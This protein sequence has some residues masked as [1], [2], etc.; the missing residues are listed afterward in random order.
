MTSNAQWEGTVNMDCALGDK[1][2]EIGLSTTLLVPKLQ[3]NLIS[4]KKTM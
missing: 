1:I 2:R 4:V 3:Q